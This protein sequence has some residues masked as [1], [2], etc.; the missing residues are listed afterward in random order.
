MTDTYR[1]SVWLQMFKSESSLEF[2]LINLPP[3]VAASVEK[4]AWQFHHQL[5][6]YD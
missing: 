4:K 1:S 2:S 5:A 6:E 3:G